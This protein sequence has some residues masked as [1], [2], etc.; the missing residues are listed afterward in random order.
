M[1]IAL[2]EEELKLRDTV[3]EYFADLMTPEVLASVQQSV[4]GENGS[5]EHYK[6]LVRQIAADGWLGIGWPKEYG[7]QERSLV[8]QLIFAEEAEAAFVPLPSLA[9]TTVG[10][11][12]MRFGTEEQKRFFLPKIVA[13]SL[14]VAIGY[15]EPN[16]G[17]DL[18][19]LQTRAV[20]DG[21]EYVIN[22][23]KMWTSLMEYADYIWLAAR[24]DPDAPPH[25]GITVFLAPADAAGISR[26]PV[27]TLG[28]ST[29][30]TYYDD[31]RVPKENVVLGE[32]RGWELITSQ[33]NY[34]RVLIGSAGLVS[35]LYEETV[36]WATETRTPSGDRVID[37]EWVR[38]HLGRI[39]AKL[40]VQKLINWRICSQDELSPAV[41]SATKVFGSEFR[42][43]ACR[44]MMEVLGGDSVL[45]EGSPGA[46]LK[47]RMEFCYRELTNTFGG[48]TNEI[49]RDMI[50]TVG[51][52]MPRS[53]R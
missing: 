52:G 3:R 29:N 13:G 7:G 46:L 1:D 50:A 4:E 25:K 11:T 6:R 40:E 41:A 24:T 38:V 18:A 14:H 47:G 45:E 8:E 23:Q 12:I 53:P 34:E 33:L 39:H 16:A 26:T 5:P 48:G 44:L 37:R 51:L 2:N 21:D 15:S 35:R 20:R 27:R 28:Y 31:V 17:T 9:L 42:L 43:E 36:R 19:S 22:G 10:P 49:Q 32:N 30:A